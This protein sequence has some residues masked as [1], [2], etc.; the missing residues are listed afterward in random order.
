M[1]ISTFKLL[2][3]PPPTKPYSF[4]CLLLG[5]TKKTRLPAATCILLSKVR[6]VDAQNAT[7]LW[8]SDKYQHVYTFYYPPKW[9]KHSFMRQSLE[10][11][12]HKDILMLPPLLPL[13]ERSFYCFAL[14]EFLFW[15]CHVIYLLV[16]TVPTTCHIIL[17]A[18]R[19]GD[20]TVKWLAFASFRFWYQI[21][22][23]QLHPLHS[24]S[25]F[26]KH[27]SNLSGD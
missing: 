1:V 6:L 7:L 11:H 17:L 14:L 2:G 23:L 8:H 21:L 26:Q 3:L 24:R 9:Y 12:S 25:R 19:P 22:N 10:L 16:W 20:G 27:F 4:S 18:R 5:F 13:L 15:S